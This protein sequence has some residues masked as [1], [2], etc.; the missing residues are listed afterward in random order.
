MNTQNILNAPINDV[1]N[2]RTVRDKIVEYLYRV[3]IVNDSMTLLLLQ[4]IINVL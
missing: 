2:E 1:E 3:E 4:Q